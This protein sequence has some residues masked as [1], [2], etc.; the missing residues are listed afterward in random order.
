ML[1]VESENGAQLLTDFISKQV[2]TDI[3]VKRGGDGQ[4]LIEEYDKT[5]NS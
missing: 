1:D 5:F 3:D 2:L 4:K